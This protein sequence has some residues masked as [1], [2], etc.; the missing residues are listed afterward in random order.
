MDGEEAAEEAQEAVGGQQE[1]SRGQGHRHSAA[2]AAIKCFQLTT[3]SSYL[4]ILADIQHCNIQLT[5]NLAG[6]TYMEK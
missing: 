5:A 4:L 1:E 2:F 3:H 6:A